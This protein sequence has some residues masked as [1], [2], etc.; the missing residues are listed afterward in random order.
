M[1]ASGEVEPISVDVWTLG[2]QRSPELPFSAAERADLVYVFPLRPPRESFALVADGLPRVEITPETRWV[3][4][5]WD[6]P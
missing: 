3:S 2:E 4:D 1:R 6:E 5:V